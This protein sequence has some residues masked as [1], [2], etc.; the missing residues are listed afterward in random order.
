MIQIIIGLAGALALLGWLFIGQVKANGAFETALEVSQANE[1]RTHGRLMDRIEKQ[2]E[3]EAL[4]AQA[5]KDKQ[6]ARQSGQKIKYILKEV[7]TNAD[8]K[9]CINQPVNAD[10]LRLL[11]SGSE[12]DGNMPA[13]GSSSSDA[14]ASDADPGA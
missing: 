14:D 10:A 1:Q 8:P 11:R 3:A 4:L 12:S 6:A 13:A 5:E 9:D 2:K 7:K